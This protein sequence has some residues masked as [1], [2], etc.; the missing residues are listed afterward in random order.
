MGGSGSSIKRVVFWYVVGPAIT[1]RRFT[2]SSKHHN[3]PLASVRRKDSTLIQNQQTRNRSTAKRAQDT[4]D[5]SADG[6]ACDVAGATRGDLGKHTDLG[7]E[8]ADVTE[9]AETVGRDE[10]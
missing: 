2:P 7:A 8:G 4:G 1:P 9:A 5:Q 6:K 10:L 3:K